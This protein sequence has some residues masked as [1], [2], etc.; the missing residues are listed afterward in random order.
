MAYRTFTRIETFPSSRSK[1]GLKFVGKC[2]VPEHSNIEGL[3]LVFFH[4]AGSRKS[5]LVLHGFARLT[6]GGVL[7]KEVWETVILQLLTLKEKSGRLL[8]REA[9]TF[10]MQSHGEAAKYN[11][12]ILKNAELSTLS[13]VQCSSFR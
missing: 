5:R 3:T 4:C 6:R 13:P 12:E 2:Y 11:K 9:W 7:D 8:V 10:D 1:D